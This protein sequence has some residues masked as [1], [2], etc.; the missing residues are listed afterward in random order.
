[1]TFD[2]WWD[3]TASTGSPNTYSGWQESCRQAWEAGVK[4]EREA[5]IENVRTVGG[6]FAVECEALIRDRG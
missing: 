6:R 5:C 1:M 4:E 3:S 2:Q